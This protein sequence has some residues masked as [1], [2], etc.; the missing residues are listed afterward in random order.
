PV[1]ATGEWSASAIPVGGS[2]SA[3]GHAGRSIASEPSSRLLT[4]RTP[5]RVANRI[6]LLTLSSNRQCAAARVAWPQRSSSTGPLVNQ[7]SRKSALDS[8]VRMTKDVS[9]RLDSC[10]TLALHSSGG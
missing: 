1:Q 5:L 4:V 10:A 2:T 8:L 9:A 7:R 3:G 6:G